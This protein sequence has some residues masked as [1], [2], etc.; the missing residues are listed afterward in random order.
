MAAAV[1]IEVPAVS[2]APPADV[3]KRQLGM[4]EQATIREPR[5]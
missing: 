2:P 1:P 4:N 5:R 3:L